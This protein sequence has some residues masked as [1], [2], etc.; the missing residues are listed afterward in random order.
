MVDSVSTYEYHVH[1]DAWH[2]SQYPCN[3][4]NVSDTIPL[5]HDWNGTSW[6][7]LSAQRD[8]LLN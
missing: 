7:V 8:I 5:P 3:R 1:I 6:T 4:N 2:L